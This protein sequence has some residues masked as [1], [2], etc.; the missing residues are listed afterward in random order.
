[1]LKLSLAALVALLTGPVAAQILSPE[2]LAICKPDFDKYCGG[3]VSTPGRVVGCFAN[4]DS[5]S[6]ACRRAMEEATRRP[7]KPETKD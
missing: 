4:P 1:M 2:Q 3:Q 5:F 7:K 6:E